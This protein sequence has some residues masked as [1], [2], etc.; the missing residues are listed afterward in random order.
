MPHL[1]ALVN[2][3]PEDASMGLAWSA[4][5]SMGPWTAIGFAWMACAGLLFVPTFFLLTVALVVMALKTPG[6][7]GPVKT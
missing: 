3:L 2:A 7:V 1:F 5:L 6:R 4:A